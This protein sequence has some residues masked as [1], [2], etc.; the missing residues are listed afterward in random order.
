MFILIVLYLQLLVANTNPHTEC[1]CKTFTANK[2]CFFLDILLETNAR[3]MFLCLCLDYPKHLVQDKNS[4][5][6]LVLAHAE[7]VNAD[8][9]TEGDVLDI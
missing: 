6:V 5:R 9:T 7:K 1:V 4:F 3:L 2:F 8:L